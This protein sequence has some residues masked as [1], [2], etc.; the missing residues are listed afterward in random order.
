MKKLAPGCGGWKR[1]WFAAK[2]RRF[3]Y[4]KSRLDEERL[5]F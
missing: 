4:S 3:D 2:R 1:L 5:V